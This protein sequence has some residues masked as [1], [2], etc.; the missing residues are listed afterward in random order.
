MYC[1]TKR[2]IQRC[3]FHR[4][5]NARVYC[6]VYFTEIN[7]S[8]ALSCKTEMQVEVRSKQ[9]KAYCSGFLLHT[10][11]VGRQSLFLQHHCELSKTLRTIECNLT[12]EWSCLQAAEQYCRVPSG[13]F[14]FDCMQ[15]CIRS[16]ERA[17][18][19]LLKQTVS[20]QN[21]IHCSR[22]LGIDETVT[23]IGTTRTGILSTQNAFLFPRTYKISA[24]KV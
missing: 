8:T 22:L 2:I 23:N 15:S 1:N 17:E 10:T 9:N 21:S 16:R 4:S 20:V 19:L 12:T 5:H 18:T 24:I 7:N 11:A 14:Y 6:S 3:H 13:G